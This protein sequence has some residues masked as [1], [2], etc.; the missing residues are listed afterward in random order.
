MQWTIRHIPSSFNKIYPSKWLRDTDTRFFAR[1]FFLK[2][3]TPASL[4]MPWSRCE[5]KFEFAEIFKFEADLPV[6][7]SSEDRNLWEPP[8]PSG[9]I[10]RCGPFPPWDCPHE[11]EDQVYPTVWSLPGLNSTMCPPPPG[12]P[13]LRMWLPLED[14]IPQCTSPGMST[15]TPRIVQI[16]FKILLLPL[17]G[18]SMKNDCM[19]EQ[20][21]QR[22]ITFRLW[23]CYS[24]I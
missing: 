12:D 17:R 9:S 11:Y 1:S 2:T 3:C 24:L 15:A 8:P 14:P 13:F 20:C 7:T 16:F 23:T 22:P 19:V 21:Y 4:F 18:Q 6:W 10:L 5:Y